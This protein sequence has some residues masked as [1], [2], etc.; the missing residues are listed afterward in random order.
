MK[1]E[2]RTLQLSGLIL[3]ALMT[4]CGRHDSSDSKD[5]YAQTSN[6]ATVKTDNLIQK[7]GVIFRL[8]RAVELN[9]DLSNL[10]EVKEKL[11][12]LIY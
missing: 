5:E 4:S 1:T 7:N 6:I 3:M 12:K 2:L 11:N 10:E 9:E 8:K